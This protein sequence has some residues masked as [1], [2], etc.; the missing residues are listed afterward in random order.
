M[1]APYRFSA[2]LWRW[3][4]RNDASW[5]FVSLPE[6]VTDEIDDRWGGSVG[7]FG[8]IPVEVTVG[9]TT[10]S[11]SIFPSKQEATYVLPMKKAVR[12]AEGLDVGTTAEV[13][14]RVA[15]DTP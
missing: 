10:W 12:T 2:E 9:S 15:L 4:A 3:D 1:D 6:D 13:E 8:S 5:M 14:L 7:G 11:T